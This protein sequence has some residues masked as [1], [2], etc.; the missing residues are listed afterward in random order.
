[1]LSLLLLLLLLL[2]L[3]WIGKLL[4]L[5][6]LMLRLL[7]GMVVMVR[8][9]VIRACVMLLMLARL[10]RRVRMLYLLT[11]ATAVRGVGSIVHAVPPDAIIVRQRDSGPWVPPERTAPDGFQAVLRDFLD[12]EIRRGG[13]GEMPSR[14]PSP[15]ASF[16][17][18]APVPTGKAP[19]SQMSNTGRDCKKLSA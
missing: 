13:Q 14:A 8:L 2:L 10:R 5:V 19:R 11:E 17:C 7:L 9:L 16:L 18:S 15:E 12:Q 4:L 3:C 1:M 6:G